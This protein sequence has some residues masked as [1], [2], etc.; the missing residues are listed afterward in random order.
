[1]HSG[2]W[3]ACEELK[4]ST[5]HRGQRWVVKHRGSIAPVLAPWI[6]E[7]TRPRNVLFSVICFLYIYIHRR[8]RF[9][10]YRLLGLRV[11]I[12]PEARMFVCCEC[13]VLSGRGL[14]DGPIPRPEESYRLWCVIVCDVE[15]SITTR[16]WLT[17][18]C[19]AT[20]NIH[21]LTLTHTHTH[22]HTLTHTH[23][24]THIHIDFKR[25]GCGMEN[26]QH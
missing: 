6:S 4:V 1:M 19:C 12:P 5:V 24:H 14:C 25:K 23:T 18:G 7:S 11:R 2:T 22:T 20:G 10:G 21:T 13:C 17:L 26:Q 16:P 3:L 8:R 9:A 15:T